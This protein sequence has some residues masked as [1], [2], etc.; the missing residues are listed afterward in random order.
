MTEKER[1]DKK[2]EI[3]EKCTTQLVILNSY[4]NDAQFKYGLDASFQVSVFEDMLNLHVIIETE[5][6]CAKTLAKQLEQKQRVQ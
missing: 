3:L 5:T 4:V 2:Y 1:Q 6:G